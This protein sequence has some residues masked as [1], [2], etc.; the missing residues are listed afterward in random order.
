MTVLST[1]SRTLWGYSKDFRDLSLLSHQ[2][3]NLARLRFPECTAVYEHGHHELQL[4]PMFSHLITDCTHMD[5]IST[6]SYTVTLWRNTI[7]A[8]LFFFFFY[9]AL[10]FGFCPHCIVWWS[11]V[12]LP[13]FDYNFAWWFWNCCQCAFN[14]LLKL[15]KSSVIATRLNSAW[16]CVVISVI[17]LQQNLWSQIAADYRDC[18]IVHRL[19]ISMYLFSYPCLW[20][21][22]SRQ[23]DQCKYVRMPIIHRRKP[24]IVEIWWTTWPFLSQTSPSNHMCSIS[25]SLCMCCYLIYRST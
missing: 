18:K 5:S 2:L 22:E 20:Y 10:S 7:I 12:I 23:Y 19:S 25:V 15:Q 13:V 9:I 4:P 14:K 17:L 1:F 24:D 3:W 8:I 21:F 16:D 6:H 11:P